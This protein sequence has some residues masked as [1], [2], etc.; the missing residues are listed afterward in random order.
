MPIGRLQKQTEMLKEAASSIL[1]RTKGFLK[2][3]NSI[4]LLQVV[5]VSQR[6]A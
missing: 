2:N 6:K 1:G 4:D 3:R 5:R